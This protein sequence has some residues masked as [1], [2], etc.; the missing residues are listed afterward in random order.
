MSI[1]LE[2]LKNRELREK[3]SN[4]QVVDDWEVGQ[5]QPVVSAHNDSMSLG[6]MSFHV[7]TWT[8][9]YL[10]LARRIK[11]TEIRSNLESEHM[12]RDASKSIHSDVYGELL[13]ELDKALY[14]IEYSGKAEAKKMISDIIKKWSM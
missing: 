5:M 3:K 7:E 11:T 9:L 13:H 4:I 14:H 8:T 10:V 1:I 12:M 6:P 2:A